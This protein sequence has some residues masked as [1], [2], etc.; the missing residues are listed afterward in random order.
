MNYF[1]F[2]N[3]LFRLAYRIAL[4]SRWL[5]RKPACKSFGY[6]N[7]R[8]LTE[9]VEKI[10]VINLDRQSPRW[11]RMRQELKYI[12]D[13][14]NKP[15]INLTERFSAVDARSYKNHP[16]TAIVKSKYS[17]A[18]QLSVDPQPN[19]TISQI[20]ASQTIE[21]TRQEI[22]VALSHI[23]IWKRIAAGKYEFTLVLEDDVWFRYDFAKMTDKVWKDI[24][25]T[26]NSSPAFDLL[27]L[28]YKEVTNGAQK[29]DISDFVFKP[30]RGLW[31][32]SGY[33]LS[34]SGA[35]SLLNLLPVC[36]PIDLWIN[37]QFE[38]LNV[39]ASSKSII[40]QRLDLKSDNSYSILPILSKIGVLDKEKPLLFK[41]KLSKGPIFAFG[42]HNTGLT[43]LAMAIS[44][45]GYRCCSDIDRIPSLENESLLH[46]KPIRLFDGY[47]N[48]KSLDE[49]YSKLAKI[50]PEAKF[51]V[52]VN[53]DEDLVKL[54]QD[55][56]RESDT[57]DKTDSLQKVARLV[58][59]IQESSNNILILSAQESNKW[60]CICKFLDCNH[61]AYQYPSLNDR[62]YRKVYNKIYSNQN[63]SPTSRKMKFD[64]SPWI[65]DTKADWNGLP[66][67]EINTKNKSDETLI[68]FQEEFDNFDESFWELRRDTFPG[69][70]AL[71]DP[72]NFSIK[73]NGIAELSLYKKQSGVR[74]YASSSIS[75]RNSFLYGNFEAEVRPT[76]V[77]GV[78]TGVFLHRNSPRQEIDIEFL[79]KDTT[80]LLLNVYYN[81]GV[82]G[83]RLEYGYRGTP[84]IIDLGFDASREFHQYRIEWSPTAIRWFVDNQI[85]HERFN[86]KP[87]PIPHLPM[88]FHS[89][90]WSP[91]SVELAGKLHE[92]YLPTKSDVRNIKIN[93]MQSGGK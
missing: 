93:A 19:V 44:M 70:L 22:A 17:L 92:K 42:E 57:I 69:N 61:P 8:E 25:D 53:S 81:P 26:Q 41:T 54:N 2:P 5:G 86:W 76:N 21:M 14:N 74:D 15:L 18:D 31:Y 6:T 36:G 83:T 33:V 11:D 89:N 28:S 82:D 39:F 13:R 4:K 24:E 71:F 43:S 48:V 88:Q 34:K 47:V 37:L 32:L 72:S 10:Y 56:L 73:E 3:A 65:I 55:I 23:E 90:I 64:K 30:Y 29:S 75:T 62:N 7:N 9:T 84:V 91:R 85:V 46:N 51:I 49:Q 58:R 1:N 35:K 52:T 45:L 66:T 12:F 20:D 27:Y 80:K 68:N 87:T 63:N 50:Y 59:Q 38:K 16:N 79:G 77:S 60:N 40:N 78:L 67:D